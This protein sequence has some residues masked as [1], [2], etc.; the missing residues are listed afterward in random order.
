MKKI[1]FTCSFSVV[2][3]MAGCFATQQQHKGSAA[4]VRPAATKALFWFKANQN[5]DGSWGSKK[6]AKLLT[7]LVML[8]LLEHG[9]TPSSHTLGVTFEQGLQ[10]LEKEATNSDSTSPL[11]AWSLAW[12]YACTSTRIARL[13]TPISKQIKLII[14]SQRPDGTFKLEREDYSPFPKYNI[15]FHCLNLIALRQAYCVG[16]YNDKDIKNAINK[17]VKWLA[18]N[19]FLNDDK[20][21]TLYPGDNKTSPLGTAIANY[22]LNSVNLKVPGMRTGLEKVY[23][24]VKFQWDTPKMEFPCLTWCFMTQAFFHHFQGVGS[25]WKNWHKAYTSGLQKHQNDAGYW[26]HPDSGI[27]F[28]ERKDK[29]IFCTALSLLMLEVYTARLPNYYITA[30]KISLSPDEAPEDK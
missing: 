27:M 17:G 23:Q 30:R 9:E 12:S 10:W 14:N 4:H 13:E 18:K 16:A 3:L 5:P 1:I 24:N 19:C 22:T 7:P 6:S 15:V 8:S 21:F 29:T 26:L 28:S 20:T 11:L 2:L 25:K